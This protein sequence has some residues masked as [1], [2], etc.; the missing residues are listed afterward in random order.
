MDTRALLRYVL[1]PWV[2]GAALLLALTALCAALGLL[3]VARQ[4]PGSLPPATAILHVIPLPSATPTATPAPPATPT[5]PAQPSQPGGPISIGAYVQISGT[6]G[7][8]LRMRSQPG[9]NG[10]ILFL[11]LEAEVFQIVE[12]PRQADGY[13]WWLAA[14]PY[15]PNVQGWAVADY[16]TIVQNP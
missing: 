13:T 15:D 5:P 9:L 4:P 11:G 8:G 12:G 14:A 6:G 3:A 2:I 1:S 7:D 16:L 10:K